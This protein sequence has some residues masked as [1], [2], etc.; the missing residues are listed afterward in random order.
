MILL[1]TAGLIPLTAGPA[2]A[3][4]PGYFYLLNYGDRGPSGAY[5]G[6]D[7]LNPAGQYTG[8]VYLD[9]AKTGRA[10]QQWTADFVTDT[11]VR[12]RN[13]QYGYCI[14]YVV[15]FGGGRSDTGLANCNAAGTVWTANVFLNPTTYVFRIQIGHSAFEAWS[16]SVRPAPGT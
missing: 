3:L 12:L 9:P 5:L 13:R 7:A 4:P 14:A 1:L 8:Y 10:S 15:N 11:T 16:P 6:M 2:E